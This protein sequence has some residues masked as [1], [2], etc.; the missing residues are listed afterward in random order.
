MH[1]CR[2]RKGSQPAKNLRH[3]FL[4]GCLL[5]ETLRAR[6][7]GEKEDNIGNALQVDIA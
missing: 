3:A 1:A 5:E 7:Y 4:N 6:L 2:A